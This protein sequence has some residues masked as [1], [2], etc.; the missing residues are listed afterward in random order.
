MLVSFIPAYLLD[1]LRAAGTEVVRLSLT[2][3][4][5]PAMITAGPPAEPTGTPG[6]RYLTMS[7]RVR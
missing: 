4:G 2:Q 5:K 6:F 3:S 7:L 1:G